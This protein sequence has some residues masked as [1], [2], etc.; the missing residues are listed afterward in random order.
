MDKME[1]D[2]PRIQNHVSI[3]WSSGGQP[4]TN[5]IWEYKNLGLELRLQFPMQQQNICK[6]TN[7]RFFGI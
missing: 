7:L 5:E 3:L 2:Q 4:Y 1:R 6:H